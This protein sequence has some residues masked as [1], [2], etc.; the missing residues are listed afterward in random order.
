MSQRIRAQSAPGFRLIG[1]Q[2]L[3]QQLLKYGNMPLSGNTEKGVSVFSLHTEPWGY[4]QL[5]VVSLF[6]VV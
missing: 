4:S 6:G 2:T 3:K 1:S 5:V